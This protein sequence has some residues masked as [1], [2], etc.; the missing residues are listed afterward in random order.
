MCPREGVIRIGKADRATKNG[1]APRTPKAERL[2]V[3][4]V[5]V[6]VVVHETPVAV[7][8]SAIANLEL[9]TCDVGKRG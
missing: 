2:R 9:R 1:A 6:G 7:C 5:I 4:R 8:L 3:R